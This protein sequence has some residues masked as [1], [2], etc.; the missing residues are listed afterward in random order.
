MKIILTEKQ[1]RRCNGLLEDYTNSLKE[2]Q[3]QIIL[4]NNP[5]LDNHHTGIRSINDIL[6]FEEAINSDEWR[7]YEE[8]DPD[9][10]REMAED[11]INTGKIIIYSSYPITQGVFVTP[12]K[13]EAQ[14][15]SGNGKIYAKTVNINDVAWIDPTQGQ[16][17]NVNMKLNETTDIKYYLTEDFKTQKLKYIQQGYSEDIVNDYLNN[18]REIKDKKYKQVFDPINGV[19]VK[20]RIDVDSYKDFKTLEIV[21]DY[22]KGQVN[23]SNATISKNDIKTSGK[24]IYE[25]DNVLIYYADSSR[26]CVEY[27]GSI[28]YSWCIARS[29]SSNMYN[30]YRYRDHEPAFYFVKIK[31]RAEKELD[32]W[33]N[34]KFNGIFKDP[35]HFFVVQTKKNANINDENN[36]QYFVT[37]ANNDGDKNMSWN[38]IIS[39]E[40]RLSDLQYLFIPK[41]LSDEEKKD[42]EMFKNGLSD[43]E[44]CKLSFEKKQNYINIKLKLTDKQFE[45]SPDDLK[46][47]YIGMGIPLSD[48]QYNAIKDN[49]P[50]MKRYLQMSNRLIEEANKRPSLINVIKPNQFKIA[51]KILLKTFLNRYYKENIYTQENGLVKITVNYFYFNFINK[52]G[53]LI[54]GNNWIDWIGEFKNGFAKILNDE[55]KYNIIRTNYELVSNVWY[56]TV[57]GFFEG[58]ARIQNDNGEWNLMNTEGEIISKIWFEWVYDFDDG[59]SMGYTNNDVYEIKINGEINKIT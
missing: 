42:Y 31:D 35:Y 20:N 22:V 14:S 55:G 40:P 16:Y 13:M 21:V 34:N 32:N 43:E 18:F 5:M 39:I 7:E 29:D 46:K 11:A 19:E 37:S 58:F 23:V 48:K 30:T 45:C 52:N 1:Y 53:E 2:K 9:Y 4:H 27:K 26:A 36:K 49:P 51:D 50:L 8:Y 44:Y 6:T 33:G 47:L 25:D 59:V 17:V 24:P 38:D 41:P 56:K 57:M 3:L 10:T 15:Y 54:F 28:P 12:S